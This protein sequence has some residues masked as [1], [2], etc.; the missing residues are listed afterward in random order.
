MTYSFLRKFLGAGR[1]VQFL[2]ST[3]SQPLLSSYRLADFP[4]EP[5]RALWPA[6]IW[7]GSAVA[8]RIMDPRRCVGFLCAPSHRRLG[9]L[10]V[11][12]W[13][14]DEVEVRHGS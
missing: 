3:L 14:W 1:V 6:E 7:S 8:N 4:S 13:L 10:Q 9:A 2:L 5:L 12:P 11:L